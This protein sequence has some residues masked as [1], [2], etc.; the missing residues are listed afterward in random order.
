MKAEMSEDGVITIRPES[1]VEAYA[2]RKWN[3]SAFIKVDDRMRALNYHLD[4]RKI[5]VDAKWLSRADI[6]SGNIRHCLVCNQKHHVSQ[7]IPC[8]NMGS[9][10]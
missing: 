6:E 2:L 3:D 1:S 8:P 9:L 7:S 4:P 10:S 5:L